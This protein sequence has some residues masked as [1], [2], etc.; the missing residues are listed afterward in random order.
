MLTKYEIKGSFYEL[1]VKN[2][3]LA[4]KLQELFFSKVFPEAKLPVVPTYSFLN[5]L[6]YLHAICLAWYLQPTPSTNHI[7]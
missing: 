3:R 6:Y 5:M 7:F 1:Q 2:L 4:I